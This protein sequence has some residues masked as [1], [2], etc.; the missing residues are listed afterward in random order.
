MLRN[1]SALNLL[2]PFYQLLHSV[3]KHK[4]FCSNP[5]DIYRQIYISKE[6]S[7]CLHAKLE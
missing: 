6:T 1:T 7:E 2:V 5:N 3:T 4:Q